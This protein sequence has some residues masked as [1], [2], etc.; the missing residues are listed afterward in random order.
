MTTS[1]DATSTLSRSPAPLMSSTRFGATYRK[2]QK[3][4]DRLML[5]EAMATMGSSS[6]VGP[7]SPLNAKR[8]PLQ[9]PTVEVP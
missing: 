8:W 1:E 3:S 6:F 4:N 5:S 7:S 9:W 2:L